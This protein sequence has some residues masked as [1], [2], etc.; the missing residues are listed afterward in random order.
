[1]ISASLAMFVVERMVIWQNL[2][3]SGATRSHKGLEREAIPSSEVGWIKQI[4]DLKK[5]IRL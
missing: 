2:I 3:N 1:M 4:I 5:L